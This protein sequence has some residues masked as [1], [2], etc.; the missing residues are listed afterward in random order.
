MMSHGENHHLEFLNA[1]VSPLIIA[2]LI[3]AFANADGGIIM[4]GIIDSFTIGGVDPVAVRFKIKKAFEMVNPSNIV[5]FDIQKVR[6]VLNVAVVKVEKSNEI[7]FCDSGA[8]L[9]S[10]TTVRVMHQNEVRNLI[11]F[12]NDSVGRFLGVLEKQTLI[13][14][15]LEKTIDSLKIEI[16]ENNSIKS[17]IKDHLIGGF[18]GILFGIILSAIGFQ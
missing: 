18:V 2:K 17:K 14:D 11:G 8:Y 3:S 1:D 13:I 15:S 10:G 7:V 5:S 4:I 16:K 6:S 12:S 9:R